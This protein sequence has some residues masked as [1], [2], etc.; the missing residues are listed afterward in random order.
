MFRVIADTYDDY[1]AFDTARAGDLG[2]LDALIRQA[3]LH[4]RGLSI[5]ARLLI[6]R[7]CDSK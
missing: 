7:G 4:W 5:T 2:A 3:G 1:L 6:R